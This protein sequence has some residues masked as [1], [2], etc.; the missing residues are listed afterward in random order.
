M[1]DAIVIGAGLTGLSAAYEL[2]QQGIDTTLIEVKRRVGGSIRTVRQDGFVLDAGAFALA[3]TLHDALLDQFGLENALIRHD[4]GTAFFR[5]GT[6]TLVDAMTEKLAV[7]RLMRMAVS[8]V[9]ELED[10]G[11]GVCLENGLLLRTKAVISTVPLQYAERLFYG[12]ISEITELLLSVETETVQRVSW[13]FDREKLISLDVLRAAPEVVFV[14]QTAA[15]DRVPDGQVL[16]QVGF[17]AEQADET[18]V[19]ELRQHC[20]LPEPTIQLLNEPHEALNR[21]VD[22]V[23]YPQTIASV[24][25]LLPDGMLLVGSDYGEK[26]VQAGIDDLAARIL[27]GQEAARAVANFLR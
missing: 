15:S 10:G 18:I 1:P 20:G 13:G 5:Q 4:D 21:P 14:Q 22:S 7:P 3:E 23:A 11:F 26:V 27:D 25:A 17:R 16:L 12:Y 9:G 24:K 19:N 8:S 2:Q 6:Q